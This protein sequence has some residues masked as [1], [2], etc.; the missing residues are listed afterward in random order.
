MGA[1]A[2]W[3]HWMWG[4]Y[5]LPAI[6]MAFMGK[7]VR[8][9]KVITQAEWIKKRYGEDRW[10]EGARLVAAVMV[11]LTLTFTLSYLAQG[12]GKFFSVFL[13]WSEDVCA[14]LIVG[15]VLIYVVLG[16]FYSVAIT[17]LIQ[18]G[19][20]WAVC[21]YLVIS[22]LSLGNLGLIEAN[23]PAGWLSLMPK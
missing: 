6:C 17:D 3:V 21:I 12:I 5:A 20:L 16:G 4:V 22:S 13:P 2:M 7:W 1:K 19:I 23:A 10:G 14:L 18:T 8:R 11:I 9:A 15:I